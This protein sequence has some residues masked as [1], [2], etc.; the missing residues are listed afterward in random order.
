MVVQP[1]NDV[2]TVHVDRYLTDEDVALER[3]A[4]TGVLA[5]DEDADGDPLNA[6]VAERPAHGE[7]VVEPDGSFRYTPPG[8]ATR[9]PTCSATWPSTPRERRPPVASS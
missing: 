6:V 2:P 7:V 4:T 8:P 9:S 3:T 1:V 5:N